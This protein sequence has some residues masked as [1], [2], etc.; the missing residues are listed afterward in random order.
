[1]DRILLVS[2]DG[3]VGGPPSV[4]R[5]YIEAEYLDELDALEAEN[6]VFATASARIG[7]FSDETLDLIDNGGAI[8]SDG[9]LGAWEID[10]RL[11][12]MDREGIAAE[13][14]IYGT[15][16]A[17][18]PFFGVAN[19]PCS[20]E[21]RTAGAR[22][23]HRHL[24]DFM[25]AS[26]G[27]LFGIADPGP[28]LDMDATVRELRWL[29]EHRFVGVHPPGQVADEAL[30]PLDDPYYEPFWATCE[31]LGLVLNAHVGYG[32]VQGAMPVM[33]IRQIMGN[34]DDEELLKMLQTG[35]MA[36]DKMPHDAPLRIMMN[37]PR[38]L[39]WQL[40]LGGV[41]DRHPKLKIVLTEC[42]ADWV[43]DTITYLDSLFDADGFPSKR[44]PS[45]YWAEN[46]AV[47]PSS[48]RPYEIAMR[49]QIGIERFLFGWDYPHPEGTWPNTWDWIRTAFAEVPEDE[50]RQILGENTIR[51]Y[52]LDRAPLAELGAKIGPT[53]ADV[54]GGG[55]DV[56]ERLIEN[57]HHRSGYSRPAETLDAAFLDSVLATDLADLAR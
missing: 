2:A 16:L 51:T 5:D 48:P 14:L 18:V 22:A 20:A 43:P 33:S 25:G 7:R 23:Y 29:H 32:A 44:R 9:E 19:N 56:D 11:R 1:M 47:A 36:L 45:E 31:E 39:I 49:H 50:A 42:R 40:M 28:C 46:F 3:H 15:Q 57:F 13:V 12:E 17:T 6:E 8:R 37:K 10:L 35:D 53:P 21:L 54:L 41:L 27:R 52:G 55:H 26:N 24:A 38:Q 34:P 30:P 4:Y